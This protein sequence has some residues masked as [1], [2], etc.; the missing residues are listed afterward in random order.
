VVALREAQTQVQGKVPVESKVQD[1]KWGGQILF[2]GGD[3]K[4]EAG[5]SKELNISASGSINEYASRSSN[6]NVRIS[7]PGWLKD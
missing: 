4:L 7:K 2:W 6:R 3:D 5:R 1:K